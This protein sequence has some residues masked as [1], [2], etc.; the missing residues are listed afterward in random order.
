MEIAFS[1]PLIINNTIVWNIAERPGA[2]FGF[3]GG[4][5]MQSS[6]PTISTNIIFGNFS[7]AGGGGI[8]L[9]GSSLTVIEYTNTYQNTPANIV[10][11][12]TA[13]IGNM[14]QDPLFQSSAGP[15]YC[16]NSD[17][18]ILDAGP[19]IA[20]ADP[21]DFFGRTRVQDGDFDGTATVD[22]GY[23]ESDEVT[24]LTVGAGGLVSWDAS[25]NS[26]AVYNLY[27]GLLSELVTSCATSC[28]YS[29]DPVIVLEA[30]Q[31]CDLTSPSF[32]DPDVP[33]LGDAHYYLATGEDLVE[34]G[35]GWL[36]GATRNH[37]N[38]CL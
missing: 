3:G 9:G 36:G 37:D 19:P 29:Q 20:P 18:P 26:S 4:L 13:G 2:A 35:L 12:Y 16:V 23:C 24:N 7:E 33:P 27:R 21:S 14:S 11:S 25:A 1:F 30:Q 6:D 31:V 34:G 17:S 32:T 8:D 10:G 15:S 28:V 5:L 22:L 38:P